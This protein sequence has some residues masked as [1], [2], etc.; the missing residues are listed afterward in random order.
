MLAP[1]PQPQVLLAEAEEGDGFAVTVCPPPAGPGHDRCFPDYI[2]A[3]TY[4]RR[5]RW[6]NGWALVDRVDPRTKRKAEEAEQRRVE[7]KRMGL[8]YGGLGAA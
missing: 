8:R 4:A 3:R 7:A 1:P 6:A 2:A 5:L